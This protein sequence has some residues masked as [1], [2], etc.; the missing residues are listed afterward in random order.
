ME[1]DGNKGLGTERKPYESPTVS[2]NNS[3]REYRPPTIERNDPLN[4]QLASMYTTYYYYYSY[5]PS[6]YYYYY[7]Y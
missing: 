6:Y 4:D 2:A 7:Y 3:R 5:S 1:Q